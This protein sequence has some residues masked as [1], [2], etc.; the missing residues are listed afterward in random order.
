[1][2]WAAISR[3]SVGP[4]I[5]LNGRITASD[6]MII[7]GNQV[8]PVVQMFPN[9]DAVFQG[10]DSAIHTARNVHSWFEEHENALQ[11]LP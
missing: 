4:I 11:H 6:Y 1:M 10:D 3:S 7:L 8:L 5:T 9:N 2:I